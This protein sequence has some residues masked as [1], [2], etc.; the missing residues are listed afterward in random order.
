MIKLRVSW[1]LSLQHHHFL[2]HYGLHYLKSWPEKVNSTQISRIQG[3]A[4]TRC[5][6]RLGYQRLNFCFKHTALKR[7][8]VA[9]IPRLSCCAKIWWSEIGISR[10]AMDLPPILDWE[11]MEDVTR[12][13]RVHWRD[14]KDDHPPASRRQWR[15]KGA[16]LYYKFIR[17]HTR[18][19]LCCITTMHDAMAKAQKVELELKKAPTTASR[20]RPTNP[21]STTDN[22]SLDPLMCWTCREPWHSRGTCQNWILCSYYKW[23]RSTSGI[24]RT[25]RQGDLET[26]CKD[27]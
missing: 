8:V 13:A 10:Q 23:R 19:N 27:G 6:S 12:V 7:K 21:S 20:T 3:R 22:T 9:V 24:R 2:I 1:I 18:W 4:R 17:D 26:S 11:K 5:I 14:P 25:S 15:T 16:S